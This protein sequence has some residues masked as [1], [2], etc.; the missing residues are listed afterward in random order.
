MDGD[1]G[2]VGYEVVMVRDEALLG[3]PWAIV[4]DGAGQT[5]LLMGEQAMRRKPCEHLSAAW[6]AW[7]SQ[8]GLVGV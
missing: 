4:R 6:M 8:R 3:K 2:R 7:E 1:V 5:Y